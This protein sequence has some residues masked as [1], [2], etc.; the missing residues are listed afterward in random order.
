MVFLTMLMMTWLL[1][2][3]WFFLMLVMSISPP[4][5]MLL[6]LHLLYA[7]GDGEDDDVVADVEVAPLL[8]VVP[9][10]PHDGQPGGSPVPNSVVTCWCFLEMMMLAGLGLEMMMASCHLAGNC[11]NC[12]LGHLSPPDIVCLSVCLS[13]N[14][15]KI[16]WQN[17]M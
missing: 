10:S 11:H 16:N 7:T 4:T 12:S 5:Y 1:G 9:L 13:C 15:P 8:D 3:S 6:L 17:K 2:L 14:Q